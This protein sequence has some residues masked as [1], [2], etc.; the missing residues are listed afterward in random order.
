MNKVFKEKVKTE[1]RSLIDDN[2]NLISSAYGG[3]SN[4]SE[5]LSQVCKFLEW[6]SKIL[7]PLIV[8]SLQE[9][10]EYLIQYEIGFVDMYREEL[11][12]FDNLKIMMSFEDFL[13]DLVEDGAEQ[14]FWEEN[15]SYLQVEKK[16]LSLKGWVV[17]ENIFCYL[18]KKI[19]SYR[20]HKQNLTVE[21]QKGT[22]LNYS[23]REVIR[24]YKNSISA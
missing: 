7:Q 2:I 23:V 11:Q 21:V 1:V 17:V 24:R 8:E 22:V 4:I 14:G 19:N 13:F 12:N 18:E 16:S 9:K 5:F 3:A 6:H 10:Y 15:Y 20:K